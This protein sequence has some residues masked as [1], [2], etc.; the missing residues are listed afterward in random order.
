MQKLTHALDLRRT[1]AVTQTVVR[2]DDSHRQSDLRAHRHHSATGLPNGPR[3]IFPAPWRPRSGL[4][5]LT[6]RSRLLLPVEVIVEDVNRFL[7]GWAA[8]F[9]YGNSAKAFEKIEYHVWTRV[10][11]VIARRHKRSRGYGWSVLA[12]QSPDHFGLISLSGTVVAP[13]PFKA[14]RERPNAGGER[15]R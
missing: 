2:K 8:Y 14:W 1:A 7:R 15:R 5:F 11:S 13:R 9:R 6:C 4:E 12:H 3:P 10:A